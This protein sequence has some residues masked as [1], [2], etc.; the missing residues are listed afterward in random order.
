[1]VK[2]HIKDIMLP[3]WY[4]QTPNKVPQALPNNIENDS[5]IATPAQNCMRNTLPLCN[6]WIEYRKVCARSMTRNS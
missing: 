5:I 3:Q 6:D 2:R 1:M 4:L